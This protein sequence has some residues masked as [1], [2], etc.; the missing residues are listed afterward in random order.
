MRSL[1]LFVSLICHCLVLASD[2][3]ILTPEFQAVGPSFVDIKYAKACGPISC[4]ASLKLLGKE[5]TLDE[6]IEKCEWDYGESTTLQQIYDAINAFGLKCTAKKMSPRDLHN[7]LQKDRHLA[8]LPIRKHSQDI[9]HVLVAVESIDS[10]IITFDYPDLFSS[11]D[12]YDLSDKWDG[13]VLL[14]SEKKVEKVTWLFLLSMLFLL[15]IY[16]MVLRSKE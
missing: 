7:Y 14:I 6:I 15:I 11:L 5:V 10:A 2:S 12:M 4:Y 1:I 9:D 8:I 16:V 3:D 13:H